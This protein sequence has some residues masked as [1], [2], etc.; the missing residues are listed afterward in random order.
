[1]LSIYSSLRATK[2]TFE[3]R[4]RVDSAD[5]GPR[6]ASHARRGTPRDGQGAGALRWLRRRTRPHESA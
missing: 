5:R 2:R 1:M 6:P 4:R 3:L